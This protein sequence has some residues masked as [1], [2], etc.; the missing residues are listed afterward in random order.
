MRN[1]LSAMLCGVGVL[2]ASS[3]ATTPL[4]RD[5]I[6]DDR[7]PS[8]QLRSVDWNM[9]GRAAF[10]DLAAYLRVDTVNPAGNEKNGVVF[11]ADLLAR[12]NITSDVIDHGDNRASLIAR[13]PATAPSGEGAICL[14]SHIDV[15]TSEAERWPAGRGP[16]SGAVVDVD[17]ETV[18]YGRGALDMKGMTMMEI[19]AALALVDSGVARTRDL[20]IVAVADEEVNSLGIEAIV[21]DEHWPKVNCT[22][23]INEGGL[24]LKDAIVDGQTVFAISV[25]ERGVLWSRVVAEGPPGH[26][27]TPV[28]GRAPEKLL[29]AM[30]R[31]DAWHDTPSI[32]PAIYEL[33]A[34]VGNEA[35]GVNGFVLQR[36]FL[37]DRLVMSRL[38]DKPTTKAIT[39]DT[40]HLTGF[41]GANSPNV[42]PS[43]VWAQYDVRLLPSTT[44][45]AMK[46]ELE[47]LI[48]DIPGVHLEVLETK[49]GNFSDWNDPLFRALQRHAVDGMEHAVAG[50]MI[51][52]GFTDS[53]VLR[54]RGVK[55]YGIIP[56]V[57]TPAEAS[58]MHG[59]GERISLA[60]MVR[61]TKVLATSLAD[62]AT[63]AP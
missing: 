33:L 44:P 2:G 22:H 60:N 36:P 58:T 5:G 29:L 26:G 4:V 41:W 62:V 9:R 39:N 6:S 1:L 34:E 48:K 42:V 17:G 7:R 25:G 56:V 46:A 37:V 23:A 3:C 59:D 30:K 53:I 16:L 14:V 57:V 35:G 38:Q 24:G 15:V 49:T 61:G 21:S 31:F 50:P 8:A 55:A 47:A 40:V 28:P 10:D 11:L 18:V 27:S 12:H 20:V 45:A 43:T 52:P 19:H 51:S 54:E 63:A 13:I 32:H